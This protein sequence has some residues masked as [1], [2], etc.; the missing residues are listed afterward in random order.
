M[1]AGGDEAEDQQEKGGPGKKDLFA[2][3]K[4]AQAGNTDDIVNEFQARLAKRR[5]NNLENLP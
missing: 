2:A 4:T 3:F 5:T 1:L